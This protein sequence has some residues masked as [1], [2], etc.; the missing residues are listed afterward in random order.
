MALD[1]GS[2]DQ[3]E[4]LP[5]RSS[6][7][8]SQAKA[9]LAAGSG[10]SLRA[11]F[12]LIARSLGRS[13]SETVLFF[14]LPLDPQKVDF[15][16][17][18]R[19]ADN[20]GLDVTAARTRGDRLSNID[21]P[22]LMK[23][24]DGTYAGLIDREP[25][26]SWIGVMPGEQSARKIPADDLQSLKIVDLY[27]FS[28]PYRND[29]E[30]AQFDGQRDI[31][32][33]H[34]LFGSLAKHWSA[35]AYVALATLF[36]NLIGL[37]T[38]LFIMNVYDRILP[39]KATASLLALAIG[40]VI[41]LIFDLLLKLAR[42]RLIDQTG[43]TADQRISTLIFEKIL[44]TT[45]AA[46]PAST[47]DHAN[48]VSQFEFLREFFSS[49]TVTTFIDS[50]FVLLFLVVIYYVA[51]WL[52]VIPLAAFL[53]TLAIGLVAQYR[54][55]RK[56]AQAANESAERQSLLVETISTMETVKTLMAERPLLDR[57]KELSKNAS[58][59]TL[60][61][62]QLSSGATNWTQYV[63]Q[64][65]AVLMV[66]FGV[67]EFAEGRL[68]AGAIIAVVMLSGRTVAPLSQI[69][70]TLAKVRQARLS[71]KI[72]DQIMA[73]PEDRPKSAGFVSRDISDGSLTF[74][75]VGFRYPGTD[76]AVLNELSFAI[77][78]GERV[79][80]IGKIG[81]GKTTVG[82]LLSGLYQ[83]EE[84]SVLIDGI[85]IRQYHPATVR[86]AVA[87]A[88]QSTDLFSGTVKDKL[89]IGNPLASDADIVRVA[90]LTGVDDFAS[91]HPRGF[92]MPVG[93]RGTNLSGGQ[94][95]AVAIARLLL[96]DPKIVFLD[97]P[98]GAM[99]LASERHLMKTLAKAFD[100]DVT[101]VISTHR[102]SLLEL[103]D[104]LIV[105]D[106]GR[107][108]AD[109]PKGQVLEALNTQLRARR[110][111]TAK[112]TPAATKANDTGTSTSN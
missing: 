67:Y 6:K 110:E 85:D 81:S 34:W 13:D 70:L 3:G 71:L 1:R 12:R 105:L 51:G 22:V 108:V 8:E 40:V 16:E 109:G 44:N 59:T 38:P 14:D 39:N 31:K 50:I 95:Q 92:D 30:R 57:W 100:Q 28:R 94:R 4:A 93:E 88:N 90:G 27:S 52:F 75:K 37:V 77:K 99:D 83:A 58:K 29:D 45:L 36:I 41:A 54:I 7:D 87:F 24:A 35:Y 61:L 48:R 5:K 47:G 42:A 112:Q 63:Q 9:S 106:R 111:K 73:Q 66:V 64:M 65:V 91:R 60:D 101:V 20:V 17:I 62:K 89:K 32:K 33:S 43:R 23:L 19:L 72:I 80:I 98:S 10:A 78:P 21:L 53:I 26:G 56:V 68:S 55:G 69:A 2:E 102:Y 79:G 18:E 84:G 76:Q 25:D 49:T 107:V 82:R 11:A 103:V 86:S 97:E 74:S 104:R 96:S 46:R 15:L